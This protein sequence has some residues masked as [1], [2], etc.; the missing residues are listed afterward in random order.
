MRP[1]SYIIVVPIPGRDSALLFHGYSGAVDRVSRR[2][3]EILTDPGFTRAY[4]AGFLGL[5]ALAQLTR[6]GYLT[7]KSPRE[8]QAYVVELGRKAHRLMQ[9]GSR[10]G[11]LLVPT[12]DCNLRC[13][14]CYEKDLRER[15][16][17]WVERRMSRETAEAAF[18]AM[19][20]IAGV[21]GRARALTYYGGEPL[22]VKNL[23]LI[24]F[25]HERARAS[26]FR[27]FSA[28]TNGFDLHHFR[29][30]LGPR[31]GI[32]FLQITLDGPRKTHDRRR[33][34]PGGGGTFERIVRNIDLAL[35]LG[36]RVSLRVNV[37]RRNADEVAGLEALFR[38]QGWDR[39]PGFRA[40]CSP[41]HGERPGKGRRDA[42][43]G[44]HLE[45]EKSIRSGPSLPPGP[46][47]CGRL[48][49]DPLTG[50]IKNRILAHLSRREGL[51][52]W[53][54]AFC[55][56]NMAMYLFDPFGDIYPC[57]EVIGHPEHRIGVYGPGLLA[58]R[59][60][61]QDRW[62]DRSVVRIPA[63]RTCPYL[64]FCGGGCEAFAFRTADDFN[65]PHCAHFPEHFRRAALLA[66]EEWKRRPPAP[67]AAAAG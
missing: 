15:G 22:Q 33:V 16:G 44:S 5:E 2:V 25:L 35:R 61:A 58:L 36:V 67:Q 12:Y 62:H 60:E 21:A 14:Y 24:H 59:P 20:R 42:L 3:A 48:E 41:V 28:V 11:F 30:L 45:M 29:D 26:G 40:Y 43:F 65:S 51:P 54:T 18:A 50:A 52:H 64:F 55:G 56:A 19:E 7:K 13:A 1:S 23:D 27:R 4:A 10:P 47:R 66:Y 6:R 37:D 31:G 57:W 34:L 46:R 38:E 39:N 32:S 8:E 63:C 9:R 17:P 49:T 53:R